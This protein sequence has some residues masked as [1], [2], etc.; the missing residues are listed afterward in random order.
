MTRSHVIVIAAVAALLVAVGLVW[1]YVRSDDSP[2]FAPTPTEPSEPSAP[3][4][5][6]MPEPAPGADVAEPAPAPLPMLDEADASV[7]YDVLSATVSPSAAL[8]TWLE[9][10]DLVRRF[11]VIADN[12]AKGD[13]PWRQLGFL[14]PRDRLPVIATEDHIELDP[15][16]YARFDTFVDTVLS[17]PPAASAA[18][19]RRYSPLIAEALGELGEGKRDPL[20]TVRAAIDQALETPVIEGPIALVQPKVF[21]QYADPTLEA[22]PPLQKQLMRMGPANVQRLKAHLAEVRAAL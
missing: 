5:P 19:I 3:I 6:T 1:W 11:A 18:L 10:D 21:Y 8:S 7:R 4:E 2:P 16:G 14:T 20:E 9:Q 12:A 15:K 17:V 22:R 13:Y